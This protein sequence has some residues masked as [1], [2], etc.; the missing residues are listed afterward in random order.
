MGSAIDLH[1]TFYQRQTAWRIKHKEIVVDE[2]G[3]GGCIQL[4]EIE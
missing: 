2:E 1:D 4:Q 3:G